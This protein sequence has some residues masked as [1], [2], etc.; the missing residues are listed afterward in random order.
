[1]LG[2]AE[3]VPWSPGI[4]NSL[5]GNWHSV[6]ARGFWRPRCYFT[7]TFDEIT[8]S[9]QEPFEPVRGRFRVRSKIMLAKRNL[10]KLCRRQI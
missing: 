5:W 8:T 6:D 4:L 9:L 2:P 3:P 10:A 1:M 7:R